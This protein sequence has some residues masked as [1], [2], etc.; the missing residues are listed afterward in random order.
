MSGAIR[1]GVSVGEF[2]VNEF[3]FPHIPESLPDDVRQVLIQMK[4]L[5]EQQLIG[6]MHVVGALD[7]DGDIHARGILL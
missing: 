3:Q 7:V 5:L 1:G 6:D 4:T 2:V